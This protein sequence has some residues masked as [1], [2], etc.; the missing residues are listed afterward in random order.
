VVH[1]VEK[2]LSLSGSQPNMLEH[3]HGTVWLLLAI[4]ANTVARIAK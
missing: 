1:E 2:I 3:I 4:I